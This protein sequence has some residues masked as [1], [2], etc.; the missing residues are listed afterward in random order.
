LSKFIY[1]IGFS[2]YGIVSILLFFIASFFYLKSDIGVLAIVIALQYYLSQI[3]GLGL[4]YSSLYHQS[5]TS[6]KNNELNHLLNV[7]LISLVITTVLG[8]FYNDILTF[9]IGDSNFILFLHLVIYGI[10]VSINKVFYSILNANRKFNLLGFIFILKS[11]V[12]IISLIISVYSN[13]LI[14]WYLVYVYL[15]PELFIFLLIPYYFIKNYNKSIWNNFKSNLINDVK[16]GLKSFWGA[17]LLE[18]T[19]KLDI[20]MVS[21][22]NGIIVS[23]T[24]GFIVII[25]EVILQYT[26]LV[27]SYLNPIF[28]SSYITLSKIDF[29]KFTKSKIKLS[30]LLTIPVIIIFCLVFCFSIFNFPLLNK[31]VSGIYT[32][33]IFAFF[34]IVTCGYFITFQFFSQIGKPLIQSNLFLVLFISNLIL[35]LVLIPIFGMIGAA[36]ATGLSYLIYILAFHLKFKKILFCE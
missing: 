26:T 27:R 10:I 21:H 23:G 32:L 36:A 12:S 34:L 29:F 16:F 5:L 33:L 22:Y 17:F 31:Y 7:L 4:H 19:T 9:F 14:Y 25:F 18:A 35:N 24:Y 6:S 20:L 8:P 28:T 15:I 30:Y 3:V 11:A 13:V 2:I 1:I